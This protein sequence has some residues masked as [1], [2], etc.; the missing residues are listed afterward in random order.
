M[1]LK[2][3]LLVTTTFTAGYAHAADQS[4]P[5]AGNANAHQIASRSRPALAAVRY[6]TESAHG[7]RDPKLRHETLDSLNPNTCVRHRVGLGVEEKKTILAALVTAGFVSAADATGWGPGALNGVFPP[8]FADGGG[9][10]RLPQAFLAAPGSGFH[11]H[12]SY[13]GGL[14]PHIAMNTR[15]AHSLAE[16]YAETYQDSDGLDRDLIV[17]APLWHDWAKPMVFQWNADGTEFAQLTIAG[18]GS[19]HILGL[20]ESIARGLSPALVA[21]QA[22]AH[23]PP[24]VG[25]EAAVA[26]YIQAA[27]IIARVN[28][29]STGYLVLDAKGKARLP[30]V[31]HLGDIDLPAAGQVNLLAEYMV[32]NLSDSDWVYT[33]S[34]VG[35]SEVVLSKLADRYHH[36]TTDA[37]Y[38]T[39]YRNVVLAELT[40]ERIQFTFQREGLEAVAKLIDGLNH[41]CGRH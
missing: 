24:T 13:P 1:S 30:A 12:H 21:A 36:T 16:H 31:K 35:I 28:P 29:V 25:N 6:V 33:E 4:Q 34:A 18:T 22:S 8:L 32:D 38:N 10:P 5:G 2:L 27:A 7:L 26:G 9:C 17:G 39:C 40:A 19:H 11:G 15:I 23:T 3:A 41:H 37:D 20:A 14:A